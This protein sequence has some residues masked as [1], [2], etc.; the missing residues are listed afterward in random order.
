MGRIVMY[1]LRKKGSEVVLK[2]K[3]GVYQ[4]DGIFQ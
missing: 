3:K 1:D 2:Q 4:S